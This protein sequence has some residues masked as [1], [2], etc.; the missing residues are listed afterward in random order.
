MR[1]PKNRKRRMMKFGQ[2]ISWE[3]DFYSPKFFHLWPLCSPRPFK[4]ELSRMVLNFCH[5]AVAPSSGLCK[6]RHAASWKGV[7]VQ[8]FVSL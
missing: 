5:T 3:M 6:E 2:S 4:Q 1:W 8:Q 7:G